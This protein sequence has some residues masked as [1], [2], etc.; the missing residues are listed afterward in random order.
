MM[1]NVAAAAWPIERH[2]YWQDFELKAE[3]WVSE[4]AQ[5]GATLLVFPEYGAME[6]TALVPNGHDLKAG[7]AELQPLFAPYCD[8]WRRLAQIYGVTILAPS[9]PVLQ[10]GVYRNLALV[11]GAC[12]TEATQAKLHMTRFETEE[13]G[14]A[15]GREMI[16]LD[17]GPAL[18]GIAICYD[19]EFPAQVK[20]LIDA[21]CSLILAPSCTDTDAGYTRVSISARARAIEN[22]CFVVMASTVGTAPWSPAVD[23]NTGAGGIYGPADRGFPADGIIAQGPYNTPGWTYAA[24]DFAAL[25]AVRADGQVLNH[26]DRGE[27]SYGTPIRHSVRTA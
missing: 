10:D 15:A 11:F 22:Q 27:I 14:I 17:L 7:L 23:V 16:A 1:L 2:V 26:R 12:G 5:A 24:L 21:G 3:R 25:K 6:L 8:L 9:F 19:V 18:A 4:A 13:W 20:A